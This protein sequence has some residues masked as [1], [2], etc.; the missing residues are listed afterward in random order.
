MIGRLDQ[1][2]PWKA[3]LGNP[4]QDVLHQLAPDRAI[5]RDRIDRDRANTG[6]CRTL[7]NKVTANDVANELGDKPIKVRVCKKLDGD[8][9]ALTRNGW[10]LNRSG[11]SVP[12]S[13]G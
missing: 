13:A 6:N 9:E 11:N 1:P 8:N 2:D 12:G 3:P 4:L 5:L 7:V 10:S